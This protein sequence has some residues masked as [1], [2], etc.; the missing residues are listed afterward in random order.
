[1]VPTM[2]R[3]LPLIEQ[4]TAKWPLRPRIVTDP[5]ERRTAFRTARA[6]LGWAR[7]ALP[8]G[9]DTVT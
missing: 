3:L 4:E 6:E 7:T 8:R 2:P 1:V 5:A 9:V